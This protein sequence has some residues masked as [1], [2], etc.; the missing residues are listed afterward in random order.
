MTR[1]DLNTCRIYNT[2]YPHC[3]AVKNL[4]IIHRL[5]KTCSAPRLGRTLGGEHDNP[6]WYSYPM[7]RGVWRDIVY[8]VTKSWIW[9][10][11]LSI[12][13]HRL[14]NIISL[15]GK[16]NFL[17]SR[18]RKTISI[19]LLPKI[20]LENRLT[21]IFLAALFDQIFKLVFLWPLK[22]KTKKNW[23]CCY[24]KQFEKLWFFFRK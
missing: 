16:P 19:I 2:G 14:C 23:D 8:R 10:K 22:T 12:H 24:F 13:L 11:W 20:T 6:L 7:D 4:P 21:S 15:N 9:L 5:Q 17:I 1:L 3:S 18:E